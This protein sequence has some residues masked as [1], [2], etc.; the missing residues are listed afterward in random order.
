MTQNKRVHLVFG[1]NKKD[2][3]I[4]GTDVLLPIKWE[5][6]GTTCWIMIRLKHLTTMTTS[7]ATSRPPLSNL[8]FVRGMPQARLGAKQYQYTVPYSLLVHDHSDIIALLFHG[9][10][11]GLINNQYLIVLLRFIATWIECV[12]TIGNGIHKAHK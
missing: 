4:E 10:I 2:M 12:V 8:P 9:W 7:I 3:M 6:T 5:P 1:Q 11:R